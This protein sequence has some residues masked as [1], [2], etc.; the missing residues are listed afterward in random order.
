MSAISDFLKQ[1]LTAYYGK[2]V[3]Q[4]IHDAIKQCYEDATGNPESV[5]KFA[6]SI[7]TETNERKAADAEERSERKEEISTERNR[8]NNILNELDKKYETL[9]SGTLNTVGS[10]VTLSDDVSNY[11]FIEIYTSGNDGYAK[12]FESGNGS[13]SFSSQNIPDNS[14]AQDFMDMSEMVVSITNGNK[15]T[16]TRGRTVRWIDG[17]FQIFENDCEGISKVV[18]IKCGVPG[19]PEVTDLRIGADGETYSTAGEA[20]RTQFKNIKKQHETDVSELKGDLINNGLTSKA[21]LI[22][23]GSYNLNSEGAMTE[24]TRNSYIVK[25][26][27]AAQITIDLTDIA[28]RGWFSSYP[29][30]GDVCLEQTRTFTQSGKS[31]Y[32]VSENAKYLFVSMPVGGTMTVTD[33]VVGLKDY[34]DSQDLK[35]QNEIDDLSEDRHYSVVETAFIDGKFVENNGNIS[36]SDTLSRTEIIDV[37][38]AKSISV[39]FSKTNQYISSVAFYDSCYLITESAVQLHTTVV[40]DED[41][42]VPKNAKYAVVSVETSKKAELVIKIDNSQTYINSKK[43]ERVNHSNEIGVFFGDSIMYGIGVLNYSGGMIDCNAPDY[44]SRILGSKIYNAGLGGATLTRPSTPNGNNFCELVDAICGITNWDAID[45]RVENAVTENICYTNLRTLI[46]DLKTLD[47]NSVDFILI[48]YGTNDWTSGKP[49]GEDASTYDGEIVGALKYCINTLVSHFPQLKIYMVAPA[50]RWNKT[51]GIDS[52]EETH[53]DKNLREYADGIVHAS[54]LLGI[55]CK[56]LYTD[57]MINKYNRE[58]FLSDGVHRNKDGYKLLG[59]QY[60]K[61]IMSN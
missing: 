10:P 60:A 45:A 36:N 26:N 30:V 50:Y 31:T 48:A 55:P 56:N 42:E 58:K 57:G 9:W 43:I 6:N 28:F 35:M 5:A 21:K 53:L 13:F 61:F 23:Y 4:S 16:I 18:G 40:K 37:L 33:E 12:R 47:F 32:D 59:E 15:L 54:N 14:T 19:N 41:I 17:S 20:A 7:M 29:K 24:S 44:A 46:G 22:D 51:S 49:I 34:V 8:I 27:D 39:N 2:D 52:D 25:V 11:D 1:I 38:N 3:R